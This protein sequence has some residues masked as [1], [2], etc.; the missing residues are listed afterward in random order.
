M[1]SLAVPA[2]RL[3]VVGTVL[4][5]D[6]AP[7]KAANVTLYPIRSPRIP[8]LEMPSLIIATAEASAD[9]SYRLEADT[10]GVFQL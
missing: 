10:S 8:L 5:A 1:A 9:G 4:G 2:Q 7:M 6:G 3:V